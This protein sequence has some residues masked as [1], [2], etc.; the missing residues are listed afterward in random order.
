MTRWIQPEHRQHFATQGY[1]VIPGVL[2][3]NRVEDAVRDIAAYVSADLADPETWYNMPHQLDGVVPLHHA[4]SL[5]NIRQDENLYQMFTEFF[6]THRL[7]VDINRCIFRS[8]VRDANPW[9][10]HSDIHWDTDPMGPAEEALQACIPLTPIRA[11]TGGFQCIPEIYRQLDA[12]LNENARGRAH[13]DFQRPCLNNHRG[14]VQIDAEAGD[15]IL[16]STRLPHG[17]ASNLSRRSRIATFVTMCP[18]ADSDELRMEL[19][20]L[21]LTR[22]PPWYWR[23]LPAQYDPEPGDAPAELTSLGKRLLG[24]LPWDEPNP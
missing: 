6:G 17:S 8:P 2:P 1:V 21:W 24:V 9:I 14:I 13:F 23:G 4:Q 15:V 19:E 5:W 12:W 16:W 10:S 7:R 22:R 11:N 18:P 20:E 3:A